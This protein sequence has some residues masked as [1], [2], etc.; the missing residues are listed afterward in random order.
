MITAINEKFINYT[1]SAAVRP[2]FNYVVTQAST[3][4]KH[5]T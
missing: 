3:Q 2:Y 1:E 4:L 5:V